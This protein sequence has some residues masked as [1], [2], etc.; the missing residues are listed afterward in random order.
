MLWVWHEAEQRSQGDVIEV[1]EH[2]RMCVARALVYRTKLEQLPKRMA[3]ELHGQSPV[4]IQ[5]RLEREVRSVLE[6]VIAGSAGSTKGFED[7]EDSP[8]Q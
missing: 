3:H 8:A 6:A 1:A 2:K 4:Q 7:P 5:A